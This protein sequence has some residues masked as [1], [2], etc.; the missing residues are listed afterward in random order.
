MRENERRKRE[1]EGR[2]NVRET[3]RKKRESEG[4]KRSK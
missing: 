3:E 2:E 4:R 1:S